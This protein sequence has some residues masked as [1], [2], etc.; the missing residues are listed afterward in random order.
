MGENGARQLRASLHTVRIRHRHEPPTQQPHGS[1]RR[2][3]T[4]PSPH[5]RPHPR[6]RRIRNRTPPLQPKSRRKTRK[7]TKLRKPTRN[8]NKQKHLHTNQQKQIQASHM[9]GMRHHLHPRRQSRRLVLLTQMH[10]TSSEDSHLPDPMELRMQSMRN[11]MHIRKRN[12]EKS[13]KTNANKQKTHM[14]FH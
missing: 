11:T 13:R 12:Q 2:P 14:R 1:Q 8:N 9:Q 7:P 3:R 6:P 10:W 5:R 4:T